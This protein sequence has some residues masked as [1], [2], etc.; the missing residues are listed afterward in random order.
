[1]KKIAKKIGATPDRYVSFQKV[2]EKALKNAAI[3][4]EY[5]AL[6]P[7]FALI[8]AVLKARARQGLT[9]TTLARMTGT[10]QSAIARFEAGRGNPTVDFLTRLSGALGKK[11]VLEI[12]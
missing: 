12:R 1:M 5:D 6:E 10:T 2:K 8:R 7:E 4:K 3:R 11:L 9:Q